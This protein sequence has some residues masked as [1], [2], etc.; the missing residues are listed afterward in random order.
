MS[1]HARVFFI[2]YTVGS[3]AAL[4]WSHDRLSRVETP[5]SE[6]LQSTAPMVALEPVRR[7]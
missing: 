6:S 4:I 3:L 5:S 7:A 2:I 1:R